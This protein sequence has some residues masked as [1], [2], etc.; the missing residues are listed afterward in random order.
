MG[1]KVTGQ[2]E[3]AG[4]FS[5]VDAKD[6]SGNITG[7]NIL[8]TNDISG[9]STSTGSFGHLVIAG[10]ITASG[11][12]RADAFESVTGGDSIDFKDSITVSGDVTA[13]NLTADSSS[14][15]IRL[16]DVEAGSTSKTCLLY[17]S[18]SPR[19]RHKYP[20]P[21]SA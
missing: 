1:V 14:I 9:S 19:D 16:S 2:F 21:S 15:S 8:V 17:T 20:M 4:D 3:P 5:I 6:V 13:D 11:V 12:V 10:N 18:P 7:S